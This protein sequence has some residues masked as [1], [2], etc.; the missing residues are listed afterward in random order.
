MDMYT[1]EYRIM[2]SQLDST[3]TVYICNSRDGTI[4]SKTCKSLND[5]FEYLSHIFK[6][7]IVWQ[8]SDDVC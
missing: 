8:E 5:V 7:K 3:Y 6:A 4:M 2:Y 1:K